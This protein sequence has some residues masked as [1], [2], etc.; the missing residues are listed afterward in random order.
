MHYLFPPQQTVCAF[1]VQGLSDCLTGQWPTVSPGVVGKEYL[2]C[3]D[4]KR[5]GHRL[6]LE[7]RGAH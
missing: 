7:I 2:D 6:G 3:R 5:W 4:Y 1:Y